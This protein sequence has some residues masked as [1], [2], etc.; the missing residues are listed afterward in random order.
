MIPLPDP[1]PSADLRTARKVAANSA[2]QVVSFACRAVAGLGVVV[3]L[4][5]AGGPTGLGTFQFALTITALL[6]YYWGLPSLLSR[7]V[8]RRPMQARSWIES[9]MLST[10]ILGAVITALLSAGSRVFGV[11]AETVSVIELASLG[12]IFDGVARI[13]FAAFVAWERMRLETIATAV[14]EGAFLATAVVA[15]AA[16]GGPLEAMIVFV[17][18]RALGAVIGWGI[19]SWRIG[20][21]LV[22]RSHGTFARRT[23]REASP[24]AI[25]D[26]LK[27]VQL[28]ADAVM[29]GIMKGPAAVGL[30]QACTNLVLYWN[31]L[32][33]ALNHG[34]YPRMSRAW[35]DRATQFGRLRDAS[36]RALAVIG[37]PVAVGGLL[38]APEI[39]RAFYGPAFDEAVLAFRL[40]VLVVPL[41]M[42]TN[43]LS[44]SLAACDRQRSRMFAV[45]GAAIGNVAL[46]LALI[47]RWSYVGSAVATLVSETALLA[48]YGLLLRRVAGPS[49]IGRAVRLPIVACAPF[50]AAVLASAG[51]PLAVALVAGV[52]AYGGALVLAA[53]VG[54]GRQGHSLSAALIGLVRPT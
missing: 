32:A 38:L 7:E 33:R 46:N 21:V 17:I 12:M 10:F 11:S 48:S 43:T 36:C 51:A 1:A 8:A 19:S 41:R 25:S 49:Q 35:P 3:A 42:M 16:G 20:S 53:I 15:I 2:W 9:G 26:I 14:Q 40:L 37:M 30:Y 34:V 18:S 50:A 52:G 4:A 22:P 27:L 24:F 47:P 5:R 39:L 44:I 29:L 31:V 23:A 45:G 13:H 28:R 54:A 6:P